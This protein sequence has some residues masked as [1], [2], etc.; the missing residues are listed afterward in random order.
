M[1]I[2]RI[3]FEIFLLPGRVLLWLNFMFP[4]KGKILI[5][6]RQ[7]DSIVLRFVYSVFAWICLFWFISTG[8]SASLQ[9]STQEQVNSNVVHAPASVIPD[10]HSAQNLHRPVPNSNRAGQDQYLK[11]S[12]RDQI[13]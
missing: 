1:A 3:I 11:Y 5:S 7:K 12:V 10:N 8:G 2:L 4:T 13:F 6:A 9:S